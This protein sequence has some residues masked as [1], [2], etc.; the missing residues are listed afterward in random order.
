MCETCPI[1]DPLLLLHDAGAAADEVL[2]GLRVEVTKAL[3]LSTPRGF[4]RAVA[5]LGARLR[6]ATHQSDV[7]AV[8][9]AVGSLDVDWAS[10]TPTERSRLVSRALVEAKRALAI[11][12]VRIRAP[13]GEAAE[14]VI[15]ATRSDARLRQGLAI[16]AE[17]NALDRRI[18]KHIVR[19]QGN[20]VRDE[21]GRRLDALGAQ[22]KA[23]VAR[24]LEQGLGRADIAGDLERAAR[25]ALVERSRGYW[26]TV[27]SAFVG[28][29][30][31]LAQVS[32][33]AEAGIERYEIVAVLDERTTA[34]CRLMHGRVVSVEASLRH[35]DRVDRLS[36]P[37]DVKTALPWAREAVG[38]ESGNTLLY[39]NTPRGRV[40]LAEVTRSGVGTRDD[41]GEFRRV[42]SDAALTRAGLMW[43]PFHGRCRTSCLG[44][45]AAG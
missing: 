34:I 43:P 8:R 31:S 41:R 16:S 26:E 32:S 17:F 25:S 45:G 22:A 9:A 37:E 12:P 40:A 36:R 10:T 15:R 30:R 1:D 42:A 27:A 38:A 6:S 19:F 3:D 39:V 20:F 18:A 23:I 4:D 5:V 21:Y 14:S 35:F 13:F 44:L 29:G 2:R 11:V 7:A 24:G 28:Q 33:Y